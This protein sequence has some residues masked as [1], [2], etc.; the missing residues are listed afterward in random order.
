MM[1]MSHACAA[2]MAQR[3]ALTRLVRPR[4]TSLLPGSRTC[5]SHLLRS[6]TC[7]LPARPTTRH[8]SS[9]HNDDEEE[10]Y[11]SLKA[12]DRSSLGVSGPS[13][14]RKS[15]KE[16]HVHPS[17]LQYIE[18]IGVGISPRR[19]HRQRQRSK[20]S[21]H[22][23]KRGRATDDVLDAAAEKEFFKNQSFGRTRYPPKHNK[24]IAP[25]VASHSTTNDQHASSSSWLPPLPFAA[26]TKANERTTDGHTVKR[27]PVKLL[28]SAGSV[29]DEF[30]RSTK[31]LTEV[32]LAGRSNVGK[33][34]LLNALL[35]GN[36][37][38]ED[39]VP[40]KRRVGRRLNPELTKMPRGKKAV[41]SSKPGE[42]RMISLY[43]LTA[44][45]TDSFDTDD[46]GR[47]DGHGDSTGKKKGEKKHK[48]SLVLSDLPGYG[49]SFVSEERSKEWKELMQLYL[50]HRGRSLKRVLLLLDAR[51]GLKSADF[52]FL[53]M[54]QEALDANAE[55]AKAH[56]LNRVKNTL[57]PIQIV[58]TK[59]DLVKQKYLARRVLMV[60]QQLSKSLRREP[61]SLPVML[62]S[63]KP[64]VGFNNVRHNTAKGG[65]LEL[66]RELAA[67]VPNPMAG[68][69]SSKW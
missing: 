29:E 41:V 15:F 39:G 67:L 27:L 2:P 26:P 50:L 58:L 31:G 19:D 44:E 18:S 9:A 53:D 28:G 7:S 69:A 6:R 62:V 66:Q 57:P 56:G 20:P 48:T 5:S 14:V 30:P 43:Q 24:R 12:N 21:R 61:S 32:A 10:W 23:T 49:F 54:L 60:R 35:Y 25:D 4:Y 37:P 42:T 8:F 68:K 38:D 36:Q 17:I 47:D 55:L 3:L 59:C 1:S 63:A 51:H 65:V 52:E 64:G 40:I 34:T 22:Q 11:D 33:S 13:N 46:I 45:I 16:V